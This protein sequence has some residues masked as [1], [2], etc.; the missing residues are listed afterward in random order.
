MVEASIKR[1]KELKET[2]DSSTWF[3]D[4]LTVFSESALPN[5][6]TVTVSEA[7]KESF[8]SRI[9]RPYIQSV[10]DHISSRMESSGVFSAFSIFDPAHLPDSEEDLPL[11]G[12]EKLRTIISFYGS[13][14]EVTFDGKTG[15]STPD[16]DPEATAAE[17]KIF[18][19]IIFAQYHSETTIKL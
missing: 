12:L 19:N 13:E 8:L 14:Q 10:I 17:W 18:R 1:L 11:Y 15:L 2:P 6:N 5:F 4:H 3:K 9:Y 16:V 7:A